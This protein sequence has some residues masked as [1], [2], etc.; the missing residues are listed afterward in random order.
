MGW[1]TVPGMA[2][3]RVELHLVHGKEPLRRWR[4]GILNGWNERYVTLGRLEDG[5]W[6]AN[7]SGKGPAFVFADERAACSLIDRWLARGEWKPVPACYDARGLPADG[8]EWHLSGGQ[9]LPGPAPEA[10]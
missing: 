5:R 8:S 1:R 10:E 2:H 3:G 7:H 4:T 6:Y 9:W